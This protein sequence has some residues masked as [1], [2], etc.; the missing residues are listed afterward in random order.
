MIR[1]KQQHKKF[2]SNEPKIKLTLC[3]T[4]KGRMKF[5]CLSCIVRMNLRANCEEFI[6]RFS[7]QMWRI[8]VFT[9]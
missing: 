8:N 2:H 7:K 3:R 4:A 1:Q 5:S 6:E 9:N